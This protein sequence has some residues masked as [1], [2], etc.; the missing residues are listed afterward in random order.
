MGSTSIEYEDL[1]A[2]ATRNGR[3]YCS[4]GEVPQF[5]RHSRVLVIPSSCPSCAA[6][7]GADS[8]GCAYCGRRWAAA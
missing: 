7:P 8:E 1:R 4:T 6:P 3:F 2:W 5:R